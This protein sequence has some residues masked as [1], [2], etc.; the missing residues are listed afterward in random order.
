MVRLITD[1]SADLEP[2]EYEKWNI[3]CIPLTVF[4]GDTE[5]RENVNLSKDGFYRLLAETEKTI[6]ALNAYSYYSA[7]AGCFKP[8]SEASAAER[9][10]LQE[11]QILQYNNLFDAGHRSRDFFGKYI[12]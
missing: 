9:Q 6:P 1:S 3:T 5:Y 4:F 11:Y 8:L 7:E 2:R 12:P 10:I